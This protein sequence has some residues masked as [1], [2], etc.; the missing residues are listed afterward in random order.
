[1]ISELKEEFA[2][3]RKGKKRG[4]WFTYTIPAIILPFASSRTSNLLRALETL[5]GF[6]GI[7]KNDTTPSWPHPKSLCLTCLRQR[8]KEG[9]A[10]PGN[11]AASLA[12]ISALGSL[13]RIVLSYGLVLQG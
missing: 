10:V 13:L 4:T 1:L 8:K 6:S 9:R 11:T 5:F 3:S 12:P 2:W 7:K